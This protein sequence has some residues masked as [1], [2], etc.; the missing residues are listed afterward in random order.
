MVKKFALYF[1][2]EY[3]RNDIPWSVYFEIL[4]IVYPSAHAVY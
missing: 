3:E 4:F 1:H 2:M